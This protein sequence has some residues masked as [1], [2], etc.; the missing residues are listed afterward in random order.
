MTLKA[1]Q[2]AKM[3][4]AQKRQYWGTH[5]MKKHWGPRVETRVLERDEV[6]GR[7]KA[8]ETCYDL[9]VVCYDTAGLEL[10]REH[11]YHTHD[12]D[13]LQ[14]AFDF[15]RNE[16]EH[17]PSVVRSLEAVKVTRSLQRVALK[18]DEEPALP[19]QPKVVMVSERNRG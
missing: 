17:S 12:L 10:V 15:W 8:D 14:M 18:T 1:S 6:V 3:S 19:V 11:V 9:Y 2:I 7:A 4:A 13:D 5:P 16:V